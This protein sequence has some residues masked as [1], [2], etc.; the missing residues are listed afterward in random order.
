MPLAAPILLSLTLHSI[1]CR[2]VK[3]LE[4]VS[5]KAVLPV[6]PTMTRL[7]AKLPALVCCLSRHG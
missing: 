1:K 4:R 3:W 5:Q 7:S 2:R 6:V